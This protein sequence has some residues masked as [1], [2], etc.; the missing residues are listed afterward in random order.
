MLAPSARHLGADLRQRDLGHHGG[1]GERRRAHEVPQRLVAA[2]EARGAV[3]EVAETLLVADR[4]AAVGARAEAV[5][6]LAALGREQRDHAIARPHARDA[7]ADGLDD[8]R[9][10]VSEHAGRVARR[11]GAARGVE[12]GMADAAGLQAHQ[13]L[14]RLGACELDVLDDERPAELLEHRGADPHPHS[15]SGS[16]RGESS[17]N[18]SQSRSVDGP[19]RSRSRS[20]SSIA[21]ARCSVRPMSS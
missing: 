16:L 1:L 12:V 5:D 4:D 19:G 14:A 18:C 9:A 3:G 11:I 2:R 8:A 20:C 10:L 17:Q 21:S 7:L 6:A 15:S 13:H